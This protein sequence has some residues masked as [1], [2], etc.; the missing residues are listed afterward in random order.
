MGPD[1]VQ[2]LELVRAESEAD[3][4]AYIAVRAA[5][6]RDRPPPRIENLRRNLEREAISPTSLRAS[7]AKRSAP[8]SSTRGP[9]TMPTPSSSW[10]PRPADAGLA[11]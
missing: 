11:R 7:R 10:S 6:D 9:P 2:G 1:V 4:T 8:G 5:A 3:L